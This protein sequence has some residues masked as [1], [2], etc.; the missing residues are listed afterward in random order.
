MNW[1]WQMPQKCGMAHAFWDEGGCHWN[2][3]LASGAGLAGS[4]RM[5]MDKVS[6]IPLISWSD[7]ESSL[8]RI[9]HLPLLHGRNCW[10]ALLLSSIL[11]QNK[12]GLACMRAKPAVLTWQRVDIVCVFGRGREWEENWGSPVTRY[13]KA[14]TIFSTHH[15]FTRLRQRT[16]SYSKKIHCELT[17]QKG[18]GK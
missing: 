13:W 15:I 10:L 7:R 9:L 17:S 12:P 4:K 14:L 6:K 8:E 2:P 18:I 5:D 1:A 16:R 3:R 11:F